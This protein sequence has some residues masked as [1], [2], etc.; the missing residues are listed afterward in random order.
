MT[1]NGRHDNNIVA[2]GLMIMAVAFFA[3][4]PLVISI[5]DATNPFLISSA[6][7]AG[8]VSF[9]VLVLTIFFW[10]ALWQEGVLGYIKRRIISR[11]ILLVLIG[12]FEVVLFALSLRWVE[13]SVTAVLFETWPILLIFI[14]AK[15]TG[16]EFRRIDK[17]MFV[18][19]LI[20]FVGVV[21]VFTSQHG[22]LEELLNIGPDDA[23][24]QVY[25]GVFLALASA[26]L[27]ALAGFG[28]V[29]SSKAKS[30]A[31][32]PDSL[33][34]SVS[35]NRL[36]IFFLLVGFTMTSGVS[37]VIH[38]IIGA[39]TGGIHF[40]IGVFEQLSIALLGGVIIGCGN[41]LWRLATA[42]TLDT[43]IHAMSYFTPVASVLILF[44]AGRAGNLTVEYFLIG[45]MAI[46]VAN[47]LIRFEA[48]IRIGFKVLIISLVAC[49]AIVSLREGAFDFLGV[50]TW[51]WP[52]SGYFE[53]ITLAATVF[54]LL[55]AFRV[56][57]LVSR[58]SEEDSR[59]FIVYRKVDMLVRRGVIDPKFAKPSW[60]WTVPTKTQLQRNRHTLVF[61]VLST[62]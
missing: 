39:S 35:E 59:T 12:H 61:A 58:T 44:A 21:F 45:T 7:R 29:W 3:L 15:W 36:E 50:S 23:S 48:E 20:A 6:L 56:G 19:L 26:F 38:G 9:C 4:I 27:A 49:G 33:K 62:A 11:E 53:S 46:V 51:K 32:L 57:R 34:N 5:G 55:L 30:D 17:Q 2:T 43:G 42:M 31:E 28:W 24:P 37:A 10:R 47:L 14:V 8:M 13:A 1:F 16:G 25:I 18:F 40:E 22:G 52:G 41:V 54:T 60:K